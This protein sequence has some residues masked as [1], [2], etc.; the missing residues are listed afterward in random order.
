M[1]ARAWAEVSASSGP[2]SV[3]PCR[4]ASET[5]RAALRYPESR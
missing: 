1:P 5:T 2:I 4:A 3:M